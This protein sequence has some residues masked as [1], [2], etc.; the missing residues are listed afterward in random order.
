MKLNAGID[1]IYKPSEEVVAREIQGDFIV[2]PITSGAG[3]PEDEIFTLNDTGRAVWDKLNGK[4]NLKEIGSELAK[5]FD[6]PIEEIEK[7]ILG[8]VEELLNRK[9]VVEAR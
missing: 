1:K 3:D 6:G 8:I 9:I 5:E 7:G 4:K 2:I